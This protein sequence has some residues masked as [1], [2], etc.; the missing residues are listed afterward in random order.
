VV[1]EHACHQGMPLLGGHVAH[2]YPLIDLLYPLHRPAV[3]ARYQCFE[4]PPVAFIAE[5]NL[6]ICVD[7]F[8]ARAESQPVPAQRGGGP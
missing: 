2:V 3:H 8:L 1:V 7:D 4:C 5:A 6:Q